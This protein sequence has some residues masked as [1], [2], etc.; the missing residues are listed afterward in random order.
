MSVAGVPLEESLH[1]RGTV[2]QCLDEIDLDLL[3]VL[4]VLTP[5]EA[6]EVSVRDLESALGELHEELLQLSDVELWAELEVVHEDILEQ[7]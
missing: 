1:I 4:G 7:I 6:D 3:F 2:C 5:D